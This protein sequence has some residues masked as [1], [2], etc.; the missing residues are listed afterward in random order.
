MLRVIQG[1]EAQSIKENCMR[2]AETCRNH[3]DGA[4]NAAR[5]ILEQIPVDEGDS[6]HV[7]CQV[8][9]HSAETQDT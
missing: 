3:G 2:L 7:K 1:D 5:V 9:A 6:S 8:V 4:A